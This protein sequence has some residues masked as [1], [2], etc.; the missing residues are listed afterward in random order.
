MR[1]KDKFKETND[2]YEFHNNVYEFHEE[3]ADF[4]D[5]EAGD[6]L[7]HVL[8]KIAKENGGVGNEKDDGNEF[9]EKLNKDPQYIDLLERCD[10]NAVLEFVDA[11]IEDYDQH[12]A[13]FNR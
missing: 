9:L 4:E 13:Q 8:F 3:L 10:E 5:N 7:G 12:Y 11:F 1:T 2:V 6:I